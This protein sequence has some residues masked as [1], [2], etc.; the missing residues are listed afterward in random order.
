[1]TDTPVKPPVAIKPFVGTDRTPSNWNIV[2]G[3][4]PDTIDAVSSNG[5]IFKGTIKDFNK[6]L[7]G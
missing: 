2:A 1:M 3:E 7:K 5:T 6:A 4:E